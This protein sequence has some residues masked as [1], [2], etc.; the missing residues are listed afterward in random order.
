MVKIY[1]KPSPIVIYNK[2]EYDFIS[3]KN[4]EIEKKINDKNYNPETKKRKTKKRK[5]KYNLV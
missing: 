2:S 3:H 4:I 5:N 1:V